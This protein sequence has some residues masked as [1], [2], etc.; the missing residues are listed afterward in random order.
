MLGGGRG[1]GCRVVQ[2][3]G[4]GVRGSGLF[5]VQGLGFGVW[6]LGFGFRVRGLGFEVVLLSRPDAQDLCFVRD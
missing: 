3:L 5:G 6:G 1:A 2:G 4:F